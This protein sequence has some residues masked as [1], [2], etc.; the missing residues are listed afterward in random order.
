MLKR[1]SQLEKYDDFTADAKRL[2]GAAELALSAS[3]VRAALARR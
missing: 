2:I 1:L 3:D